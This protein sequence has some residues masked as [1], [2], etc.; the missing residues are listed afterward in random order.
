MTHE[1][2]ACGGELRPVHLVEHVIE[3][4]SSI[5]RPSRLLDH[6]SST[7]GALVNMCQGK[8]AHS[9]QLL[10]CRSCRAL[11]VSCPQCAH[12]YELKHRPGQIENLDCPK[13]HETM[14]IDPVNI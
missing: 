6:G 13:C 1:C 10:T 11:A 12:T 2:P 8:K 9:T 3:L 14:F 7:M 4:S 5:V